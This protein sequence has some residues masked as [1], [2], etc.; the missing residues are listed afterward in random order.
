ME[1][2]YAN[3]NKQVLLICH[4]DY[5]ELGICAQGMNPSEIRGAGE[6]RS[7]IFSRC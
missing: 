3:R 6:F 7:G 2:K 1:I 4:L 5:A